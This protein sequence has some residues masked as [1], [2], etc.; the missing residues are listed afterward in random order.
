M[1]DH[2]CIGPDVIA[3]WKGGTDLGPVDN[4]AAHPTRVRFNSKQENIGFHPTPFT[5]T[6]T[7]TSWSGGEGGSRKVTLFAHG[8]PY[9]PFLFGSITVNG[10]TLPINGGALQLASGTANFCQHTIGADDTNV[11][12]NI[13]RFFR[14]SNIPANP[15][16]YE[17]YLSVYGVNADGSLHRPPYFNGVDVNAGDAEP[18]TKAGYFDTRLRYPYRDGSGPFGIPDGRTMSTRLGW[19]QW[20]GGSQGVV[21]LGWRYSVLG[22]VAQRNCTSL[23]GGGSYLTGNNPSFNASVTRVSL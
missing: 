11:Y 23:S 5:G 3:V 10:N 22:Y 4:P 14:I 17:I 16:G 1:G 19:V 8:L 13:M 9:R 21:G 12:L 20:G 7:I 15:V 2:L 18:Y 6:Y